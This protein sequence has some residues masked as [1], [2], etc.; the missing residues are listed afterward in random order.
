MV[1]LFIHMDVK[2]G[3]VDTIIKSNKI[4]TTL[5]VFGCFTS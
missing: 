4:N 3:I 2:N 5:V 1:V